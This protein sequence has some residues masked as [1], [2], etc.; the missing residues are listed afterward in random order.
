MQKILFVLTLLVLGAAACQQNQVTTNSNM[1]GIDVPPSVLKVAKDYQIDYQ[2][3]LNRALK[4]DPT[5]LSDLLDF[6]RYAENVDGVQHGVVCLEIIPVVGD[7]SFAE[8]CK[9]INANRRKVVLDRLLLAQEKTSKADLKQPIQQWAPE[10]W[11]ALS[12][13]PAPEPRD[14]TKAKPS[15]GNQAPVLNRSGKVVPHTINK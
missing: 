13:Q 14:T 6:H 2:S 1:S 7:A 9:R 10:T 8:A 12:P 3:I 4:N 5:G 15:Q 11:A